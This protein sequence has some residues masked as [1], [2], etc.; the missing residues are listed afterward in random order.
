M[1]DNRPVPWRNRRGCGIQNMR[2]L[3]AQLQPIP[4]IRS[5]PRAVKNVYYISTAVLLT[6]AAFIVFCFAMSNTAASA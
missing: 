3:T 4:S 2:I 1:V 6:A 5:R